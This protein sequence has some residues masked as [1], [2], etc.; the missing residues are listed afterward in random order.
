MT[1]L[2]AR[3]ETRTTPPAARADGLG[4]GDRRGAAVV[5][6]LDGVDLTIEQGEFAA[7]IGPSGSGKSTLMNLLGC[8]DRPTAGRLWIAGEEVAGLGDAGLTRMRR[9]H[10]G[11]IFQQFHLLP[12]LTVLENVLLPATFGGARRQA[13]GASPAKARR[14]LFGLPP[15]VSR[16]PSPVSPPVRA[17]ELLTRV[18]LGGRLRHLPSQL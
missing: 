2:V 3:K 15:T 4:R 9:A 17:R 8:M 7:I 18:G 16:L 10:I 12:T 14:L 1:Q 5:R 6:A 13:P 11:F